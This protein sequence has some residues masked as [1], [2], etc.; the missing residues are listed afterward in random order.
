MACE[1]VKTTSLKEP[2]SIVK[3][4]YN[5]GYPLYIFCISSVY[6]LYIFCR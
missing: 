1:G 5:I 3:L 4:W 2:N 6:P